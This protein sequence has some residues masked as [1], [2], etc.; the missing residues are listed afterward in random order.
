MFNWLRKKQD[1]HLI[2]GW[3]RHS[4][5][6]L[7]GLIM[8]AVILRSDLALLPKTL[9]FLGAALVSAF[10]VTAAMD[11]IEATMQ[12]RKDAREQQENWNRFINRDEIV[13]G[14]LELHTVDGVIRGPIDEFKRDDGDILFERRWLVLHDGMEW[15]HIEASKGTEFR[16][17]SDVVKPPRRRADDTLFINLPDVGCAV[18]YPREHPRLL[19]LRKAV[20]FEPIETATQRT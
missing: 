3:L 13:G 4:P 11:L 19:N 17:P 14:E 7:S 2:P 12:A 16:V 6:M 18:I 9:I 1:S 15:T 20:S 5:D 8:Y 10:V